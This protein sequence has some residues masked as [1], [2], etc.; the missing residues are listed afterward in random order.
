MYNDD[1]N[2]PDMNH[3]LNW[4][5]YDW[6]I[7]MENKIHEMSDKTNQMIRN[8]KEMAVAFNTQVRRIEDLEKRIDTLEN[9]MW[10]SDNSNAIKEYWEIVGRP[11][12][13]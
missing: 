13:K 4:N 1:M 8:Q 2:D 7:Q 3:P 10:R 9:I 11:K 12:R 6:L 5:P